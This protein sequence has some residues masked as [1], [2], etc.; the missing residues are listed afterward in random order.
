MC[1]CIVLIKNEK[2]HIPHCQNMQWKNCRNGRNNIFH[3]VGTCS[4]KIVEMGKIEKKKEK[5]IHT[6]RT[7]PKSNRKS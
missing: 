1:E 5:K 6:V 4:G 2:Q 7:V 3:T